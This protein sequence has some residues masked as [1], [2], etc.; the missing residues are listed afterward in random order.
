M[1]GVLFTGLLS[2]VASAGPSTNSTSSTDQTVLDATCRAAVAGLLKDVT[3]VLD[4]AET[5]DLGLALVT[6]I[7][8]HAGGFATYICVFDRKTGV[9]E[10]GSSFDSRL[11]SEIFHPFK[12]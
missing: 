9:A 3:L 11:L 6:G 8:E 1:L 2:V 12:R 5:L 7:P 10:I 4:P